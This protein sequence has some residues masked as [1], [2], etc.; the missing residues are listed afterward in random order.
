MTLFKTSIVAAL[1]VGFS[2]AVGSLS[3]AAQSDR[4][5]AQKIGP[6]S[7]PDLAAHAARSYQDRA[8]FPAW[9]QPVAKG[10]PDPLMAQR[11][12]TRQTLPREYGDGLT[13]WPSGIRYERG[14][15]VYIYAQVTRAAAN[16]EDLLVLPR[17]GT[18]TGPMTIV[19]QVTGPV[20]GP[21]GAFK[22]SDNGTNGDEKAGD[23]IY[24]GRF[25]LP[26]DR[27]P[28]IGYAENL[29]VIITASDGRG[30]RLKGITG[31]LYSHPAAD[32]TGKY[33]HHMVDGDLVI[34]AEISVEAKGRFHLSGILHNAQGEP[35][36][37]SQN[38]LYLEPGT[39]WMDLTFY[40]L[41]LREAGAKGPLTLGSVTVTSA[42]AIP[43]ALGPVYE[44]VYKT[45]SYKTSAFHDREFYRADLIEQSR[46]LDALSREREKALE[47]RH[48]PN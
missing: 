36:A 39:R 31:V 30:D 20:S 9:S 12:P 18:M 24:T 42:N 43:N 33:E 13:V 26:A 28:M 19:G 10:Q 17:D 47:M 45:E 16:D 40:G 21:L 34:R 38:A 15:P 23:G 8:R 27:E 25:D 41:A 4:D 3:A 37:S 11:I 22:F 29:A 46:R 1:F 14:E 7:V 6:P 44:N 35:L 2:V 48:K 5:K 32:L